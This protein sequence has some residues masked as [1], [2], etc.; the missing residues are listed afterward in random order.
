MLGYLEQQPLYNAI[1]FSI[2]NWQGLGGTINSTVWNTKIAS[3]L[4]PS[5]AKAGTNLSFSNSNNNYFGSM[6]DDD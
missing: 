5:D 3:F 6:G 4:C 2:N 1:N